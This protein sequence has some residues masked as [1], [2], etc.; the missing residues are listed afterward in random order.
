MKAA[1]IGLTFCVPL[2][3]ALRYVPVEFAAAVVL[4]EG[5]L[6]WVASRSRETS[7]NIRANRDGCGAL[8]TACRLHFRLVSMNCD[9][10]ARCY[11]WLEYGM[12]GRA[13]EQTRLE[14]LEL[15]ANARHCLIL[16]DGDGRFLAAFGPERRGRGG[17]DREQ[18][19]DVVGG[20]AA[21]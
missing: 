16:G 8:H 21:A 6:F 9:G 2:L 20:E 17:C 7:A 4:S 1:I 19:G 11:R 3:T 10:I 18:R 5:A 13:L 12:F 14:Y 15:A